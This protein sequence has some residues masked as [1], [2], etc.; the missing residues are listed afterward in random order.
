MQLRN[1][2]IALSLL[3]ALFT[4]GV[5]QAQTLQ[6]SEAD[7]LDPYAGVDF[8]EHSHGF[9]MGYGFI[10]NIKKGENERLKTP[11]LFVLGYEVNQ[12][13][14]GGEAV[15]IIFAEVLAISGM[16]Q[17]LFIPTGNFLIGAEF[18]QTFRASA[19]MHVSPLSTTG[20]LV[21]MI[22]SM[23]YSMD[24]GRFNLPID[25]AWIPDTDPDRN[26]WRGFATVGVNW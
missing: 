3:T 18:N 17:G 9:R 15:D 14:I 10:A 20:D 16:N 2:T 26:N 19:G 23:G 4:G 5:A 8:M 7:R 24:A 25:I 12:R 1:I 21:H 6:E 22:A 13:L 11:S